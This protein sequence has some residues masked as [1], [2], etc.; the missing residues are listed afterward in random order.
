MYLLFRLYV[1]EEWFE[2][3]ARKVV[4]LLIFY[5]CLIGY[6]TYLEGAAFDLLPTGHA[7]RSVFGGVVRLYVLIEGAKNWI[8]H[9]IK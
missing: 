6:H 8:G 5:I 1:P 2:L 7:I 4:P 9:L 3:K